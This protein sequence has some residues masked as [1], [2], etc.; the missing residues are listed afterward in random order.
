MVFP[1][2]PFACQHKDFL[3]AA[4]IEQGVARDK[5]KVLLPLCVLRGDFLHECFPAR[6]FSIGQVRVRKLHGTIIIPRVF[7][8]VARVKLQCAIDEVDNGLAVK[9][10]RGQNLRAA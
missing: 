6:G 7:A 5:L 9:L 10:L 2:L 8:E 4:V 3:M 1:L